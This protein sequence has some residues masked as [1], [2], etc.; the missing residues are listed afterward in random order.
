MLLLGKGSNFL[1]LCVCVTDLP[2]RT[3]R[4]CAQILLPS[5]GK[6]WH[7]TV[8]LW[9][10]H[11]TMYG[12]RGMRRQA[13]ARRDTLLSFID[14]QQLPSETATKKIETC[15]YQVLLEYDING[16]SF[17]SLSPARSLGGW[18][19]IGQQSLQAK[20]AEYC[21]K[22]AALAIKWRSYP[23]LV[24]FFF[25]FPWNRY[26]LAGNWQ[27]VPNPTLAA[28]LSS[29]RQMMYYMNR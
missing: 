20:H 28:K 13:K 15:T 7:G 18:M 22:D 24:F 12:D 9:R 16:T 29:A 6:S 5:G 26:G 14:T 10:A 4:A 17:S 25:F 27:N 3:S 19:I 23:V 1:F 21:M 11:S 8:R 2:W